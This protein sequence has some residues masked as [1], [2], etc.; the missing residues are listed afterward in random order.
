MEFWSGNRITSLAPDEVFVFGSNPEGRHGMGAAKSAL[1]FGARY[2][3]GRGRQGQSYALVTKNLRAGFKERSTGIVYHQSGYNSVS[4]KQIADNIAELYLHACDHPND[5]FLISYQNSSRNLNGYTPL[6]M[7]R[8]FAS[9]PIPNN[10]VFHDSFK[11]FF[12]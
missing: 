5:R 2:G 3:I 1:A 9:L 11:Q 12:V 7:L 4:P 6:D 10:I 8:M